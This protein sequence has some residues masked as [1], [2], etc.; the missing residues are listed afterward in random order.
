[1]LIKQDIPNYLT[2]MRI[3]IIPLLIAALYFPSKTGH[4]IA[5]ALFVMASIT[6]YLDGYLARY[7][8]VQSSLGRF[9]DPIADKLLV[10]SVLIVLVDSEILHGWH[11]LPTLAILCREIMVSGLREHLAEIK[12]SVPVTKAAKWKTAAQLF[13]LFFLILGP[14]YNLVGIDNVLLGICLLWL[15]AIL[16]LYTGYAYLRTGMQHF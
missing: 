15:S 4:I 6:D 10:A 2:I 16:T 14:S 5:A 9:L 13:A 11:I 12:V 8:N 7:W 1:M 3:A